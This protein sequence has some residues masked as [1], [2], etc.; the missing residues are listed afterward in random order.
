MTV[1]ILALQGDY[2]EHADALAR[3]GL[4]VR[5]VR[6]V[7]DLADL[8]GFVLPGGESTTMLRLLA[9]EDL[10]EPVRR[11]TTSGLPV[12]GTCAGL[13]LLARVVTHPVQDS[14][15]VLDLEVVRNGYGRQFHSGTFE[16]ESEV[17]P[18]GTLGVFIR[19]PR[20]KAVG[21]GLEVLARRGE[22][23]VLVR[24][25][26]VLASCFHPELQHSHPVTHMFAEMVRCSA[27]RVAR[28]P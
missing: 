7:E 20:I 2:A 8:T 16:L 1:G 21:A 13:I 25:G 23:P 28:Q 15:G 18:A 5:L 27:A 24:Q 14:F 11:T 9:V 3:L 26:P 22:D 10:A 4:P 6:R 12:L 19:A 17:L